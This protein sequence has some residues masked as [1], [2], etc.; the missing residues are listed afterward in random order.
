MRTLSL[1][2]VILAATFLATAPQ[3]SARI[4]AAAVREGPRGGPCFTI[5]PREQAQGTPEFQAVSVLEGRRL[6]WAMRMPPGRNTT[7]SYEARF[8]LARQ[9]DGGLLVHQ[10][11]PGERAGRR[12]GAC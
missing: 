11:V 4:G 12:P 6:L 8:C 7:P 3:A 10:I 1:S 2:G 9:P 5:A